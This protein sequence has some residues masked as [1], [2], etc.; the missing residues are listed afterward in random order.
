MPLPAFGFA[1]NAKLLPA[2][3]PAAVTLPAHGP[4]FF[5]VGIITLMGL[6]KQLVPVLL[7]IFPMLLIGFLA[8]PLFAGN[9]D[10][11]LIFY[12]PIKGCQSRWKRN[13]GPFALATD[14]RIRMADRAI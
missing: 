1:W 12:N 6:L 11:A 8:S 14:H 2:D 5:E 10:T 13:P 7:A 3:Q 9:H 4:A